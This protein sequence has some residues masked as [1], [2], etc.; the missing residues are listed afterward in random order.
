MDLLDD[1]TL[2]ET[3]ARFKD[4]GN[5]M[6]RNLLVIHYLPLVRRVAGK[7]AAGLPSSVDRDDLISYGQFGL[8]AAM[9]GY[10]PARGVKFDHYAVA[11]IRGSIY[12]EIRKLDLVPRTVRAKTRELAEAQ[13]TLAT[14]LGRQPTD[15]EVAAYLNMP[16][17]EYWQH[18]SHQGFALVDDETAAHGVYDHGSNPEDLFMVSEIAERL[19][20]A[21][22]AMPE[23]DRTILAL[24]YLEEMTLAE[25]GAVLG[26]T[27]SRVCQ[28]QGKILGAIR[29]SLR[30]GLTGVR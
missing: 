6:D 11:R 27:E 3:W 26:V 4:D 13:D 10:D 1:E 7:M 29:E 15:A 2:A 9:N 21:V 28:L 20:E 25:V 22:G 12:D 17:T 19:A 5:V 23:R 16:L 8:L 30:D 14:E 24:C 18:K